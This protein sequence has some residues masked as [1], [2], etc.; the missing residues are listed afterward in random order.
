MRT[1]HNSRA[2]LSRTLARFNRTFANPVMR[3]VAG[4]LPP[5][6][7]VQHRGRV[8]GREYATPVIAFG[9]GDGLVVGVLYGAGSDWVRNV[10]A[11]GRAK[12]QRLGTTREYACARLVGSEDGLRLL[13]APVRGPYRLLGAG[14]FLSLR[15]PRGIGQISSR[16]VTRT[17]GVGVVGR[18]SVVSRSVAALLAEAM[19]AAAGGHGAG[20][21]LP[22][23]G[24]RQT[25]VS[26]PLTHMTTGSTGERDKA[27]GRRRRL[28]FSR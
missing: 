17:A 12:V 15:P 8:T 18:R 23:P 7:I 28:R 9:G 2:R 19:L 16:G 22:R 13:P 21:G 25:C 3:L 24:D 14:G 26:M 1:R 5:L 6:A 27:G 11:A 4:W 20:S 10:V